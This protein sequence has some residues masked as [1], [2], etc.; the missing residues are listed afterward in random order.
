MFC[1]WIA[2]KQWVAVIHIDTIKSKMLFRLQRNEFYW[3]SL[4]DGKQFMTS[5]LER[6]LRFRIGRLCIQFLILICF[7]IKPLSQVRERVC[8][9]QLVKKRCGMSANALYVSQLVRGKPLY[10]SQSK[11]MAFNTKLW[12]TPN[13]KL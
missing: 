6:Y 11:W 1:L 10:I 13:S 5:F 8:A 7:T 12:L 4:I 2:H 9:I 3:E